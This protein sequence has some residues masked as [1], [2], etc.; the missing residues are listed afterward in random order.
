MSEKTPPDL[1]V[2]DEW[3]AAMEGRTVKDRVYEVATTLTSPTTVADIADRADCTKEGARSH[4][5]WFVE[6]GV[7]EK[8]AANPALF[9][10]NEAYFEFRRVTELTR[11]F[12]TAEAVGDAIDAYRDREQELAA[13]FEATAPE[14]VVLSDV[15]SEDLDDIYDALS[16]WRTV[17]RRLR[18]LHEAKI[19]L[20]SGS[21]PASAS[22]LP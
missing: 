10:R 7:L 13:Q 22:P 21:S 8:V 14:A 1:N 9:V 6:L 3:A 19:R 4:L 16:E 12:E 18:E 11:E 2:T 20:E 5:E 15:E 17:T